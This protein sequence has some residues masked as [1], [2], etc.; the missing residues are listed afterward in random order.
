MPKQ[1][2]AEV[3]GFPIDNMSPEAKRFR[4]HRLCPFGNKVPNCTKDKAN[5]P[6]GVCSVFADNQVVI[7]CPLRFRQSWIIA[8]DAA[9]FFFA[10]R[11]KWTTL[12]EVRL[13]D[14]EGKSAGNVDVVLVSYNT[15]GKITD[16][17]A[18]EVQAVYISGNVR[19][20][21]EYYMENTTRRA[22][23]DWSGRPNYPNPDYLSSSRKRLAPQLIFKGGIFKAWGKKA[24]VALNKG[25]FETLPSLEA[26]EPAHA[27]IAWLIYDLVKDSKSNTCKLQRLKKVYTKFHESLE[28]IT[29]SDPGSVDDFVQQLQIKVN[30]KFE[31]GEPPDTETVDALF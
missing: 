5:A 25:F 27:D 31:N 12:T 15:T 10:P 2:L 24:A 3:F 6:L 18:L 8:E 9:S 13:K 20:P 17:G 23:M 30:Q 21:F 26:V 22:S 7:T 28:K 1:P 16:F 14:K 4:K 19:N 29:R 11:S